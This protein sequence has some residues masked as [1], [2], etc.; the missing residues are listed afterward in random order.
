ML[1]FVQSLE[2]IMHSVFVQYSEHKQWSQMV[3]FRWKSGNWVETQ[4]L[5]RQIWF[6]VRYDHISCFILLVLRPGLQ[7]IIYGW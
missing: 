4:M 7:R 6:A 5:I 2:F 1:S 3:S